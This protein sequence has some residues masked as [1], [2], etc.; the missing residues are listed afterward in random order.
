MN[1]ARGGLKTRLHSGLWDKVGGLL[2]AGPLRCSC[3]KWDSVAGR[4]FAE[5]MHIGAYPLEKVFPKNSVNTILERLQKF[6]L[7][8]IGNC[9]TCNIR[10]NDSIQEAIDSTKSNFSG[11]CMDCMDNSRGSTDEN[12]WL[13]W[14]LLA[15]WDSECRISH[16]QHTWYVSWCGQDEHRR[17]LLQDYHKEIRSL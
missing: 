1:H 10:W 3:K 15:G 11:L 13:R 5:L 17:K 9:D 12:Y 7:G 4:Y 2:K 6:G 16:G 14:D 8:A